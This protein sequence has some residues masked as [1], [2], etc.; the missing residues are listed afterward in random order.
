MPKSNSTGWEICLRSPIAEIEERNIRE[1]STTITSEVDALHE[2]RFNIHIKNNGTKHEVYVEIRLDGVLFE[3]FLIPKDQQQILCQGWQDEDD[4]IYGFSW[5]RASALWCRTTEKLAKSTRSDQQGTVRVTL[6]ELNRE[7]LHLP[8]SP[9]NLNEYVRRPSTS[10]LYSPPTQGKPSLYAHMGHNKV[11]N[12]G[13]SVRRSHTILDRCQILKLEP[14]FTVI[15]DYSTSVKQAAVQARKREVITQE[16]R[17]RRK[18]IPNHPQISPLSA[19]VSGTRRTE[20]SIQT[21]SANA[22]QPA[23]MVKEEPANDGTL[24]G[25]HARPALNHRSASS[26]SGSGDNNLNR[27]I[28]LNTVSKC[29]KEKRKLEMD[30]AA[31]NTVL[32]MPMVHDVID[33]TMDSDEDDVRPLA[34]RVAGPT[35]STKRRRC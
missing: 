21:R 15:F 16:N 24:L 32:K 1:N 4:Q 34:R 26:S 27:Q 22:R 12:M 28:L 10:R 5:V 35:S 33:L 2:C 29:E 9:N 17:T 14:I 8:R 25:H 18:N 6:Y 31:L 7:G 13:Y 30:I 19:Q 11:P 3:H 20:G 23:Q